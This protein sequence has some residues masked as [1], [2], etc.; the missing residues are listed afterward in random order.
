MSYTYL[1]HQLF[2]TWDFSLVDD[3]ENKQESKREERRVL[4]FD[5]E[6]VK[7]IMIE[8]CGYPSRAAA[9][10]VFF[11]GDIDAELQPVIDAYIA[12]RTIS[13][14]FSVEGL[15]TQMIMDKY[16]VN[17]WMGLLFMN[18]FIKDPDR[19]KRTRNDLTPI[20]HQ[21]LGGN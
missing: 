9:D 12:D 16:G 2:F 14:A 3:G 4:K 15:T 18:G 8:E 7:Q 13:D 11:L 6:L 21:S 5:K 19:A 20:R 10:E 17:F 1:C